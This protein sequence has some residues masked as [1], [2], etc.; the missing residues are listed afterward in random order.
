[1]SAAP[2]NCHSIYVSSS[3][4]KKL[5]LLIA[6]WKICEKLANENNA[7]ITNYQG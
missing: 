3:N 5:R 6:P 7:E 1:M 4:K 2:Q